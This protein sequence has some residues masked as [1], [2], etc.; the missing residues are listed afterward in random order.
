MHANTQ[1]LFLFCKELQVVN[2]YLD[3]PSWM[4]SDTGAG[5]YM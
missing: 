5:Q 3:V 2:L 4:F 1:K